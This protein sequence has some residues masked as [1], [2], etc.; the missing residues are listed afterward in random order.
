MSLKDDIRKLV[1]EAQWKLY[2]EYR[3]DLVERLAKEL[4][5]IEVR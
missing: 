3:D 1:D 4:N 2:P 5:I